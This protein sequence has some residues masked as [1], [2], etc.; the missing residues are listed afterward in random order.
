MVSPIVVASYPVLSL[1]AVSVSVGLV[2]AVRFAVA[3]IE[4]ETVAV[5]L[6]VLP[7][8]VTF[9]RTAGE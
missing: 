8:R 5:N 7:V 6:P 9:A 4:R 1:V 3:R 2:A